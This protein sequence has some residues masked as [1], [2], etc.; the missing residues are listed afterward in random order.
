MAHSPDIP[1]YIYNVLQKCC[2][3]PTVL[4]CV[5]HVD[6]PLVW[7]KERIKK[8]RKV[9]L[10]CTEYYTYLLKRK[11]FK[12]E[13]RWPNRRLSINTQNRTII[14][15]CESLF[16]SRRVLSAK[17]SSSNS[18]ARGGVKPLNVSGIKGRNTFLGKKNERKKRT[19]ERPLQ[20]AT[21][22]AFSS[23]EAQRIEKAV[24]ERIEEAEEA[25][26]LLNREEV[27]EKE[28]G[29]N[30]LLMDSLADGDA[31]QSM[32]PGATGR[33]REEGEEDGSENSEDERGGSTDGRGGLLHADPDPLQD[34]TS[35]LE[36]LLRLAPSRY[37]ALT[38]L[39][40][41]EVADYRTL[42]NAYLR[43]EEDQLLHDL[44]VFI[45]EN[46]G[47][48]EAL[49][50][51]HYSSF[52]HAVEQCL[53]I[54]P[55]DAQVVG[56]HLS[57]AN[58]MVKSAVVNMKDAAAEMLALS[59]TCHNLEAT[60][61]LLERFVTLVEALEVAETQV[62]KCKLQGAVV[63]IRELVVLAAPLSGFVLGEYVLHR[64]AQALTQEVLTLAIQ[65]LNTWLKRLRQEA[66]VI[67]RAAMEWKGFHVP[68]RVAKRVVFAPG[69][70]WWWIGET[71]LPAETKMAPFAAADTVI[72][73]SNGA[74]IQ[75]VFEELHRGEDFRRYYCE[76]RMQQAQADFFNATCNTNGLPS[77]R[78]VEDFEQFC[79]AA[80]GFIL[81]EDVVHSATYPHVQ[82]CSEILWS[83]DQLAS[84]IAGHLSIVSSALRPDP[85]YSTYLLRIMEM[86]R[87][88]LRHALETVKSVELNPLV[89]LRVMESYTDS[90][91]STWLQ[92][93]CMQVTTDVLSDPLLALVAENNTDL[94][95]YATRFHMHLCSSMQLN[96]PS[97]FRGSHVSLPYGELVPKVGKVAVEFVRKC[98]DVMVL[99]SSSTIRHSEMNN[100]NEMILKYVSVLFRTVAEALR[101]VEKSGSPPSVIKSA[102]FLS[103]C[104]VMPVIAS[105]VEQEFLLHGP[106]DMRL[107][108]QKLG[109]P[110]V[111]KA[112]ADLFTKP[113][114]D[115]MERLLS[116]CIADVTARLALSATITYW[117]KQLDLRE[118]NEE[119]RLQEECFENCIQY[120][121]QL[122]PQLSS[123]LS[124]EITR[125]VVST[126]MVHIGQRIQNCVEMALKRAYAGSD[127][128]FN[129]MRACVGEFEM[130][131]ARGVPRWQYQL[132]LLL[133]GITAAE[134]FPLDVAGAVEA[135]RAWIDVREKQEL[136]DKQN[137]TQLMSAVE[138]AGK[139]LTKGMHAFGKTFG[140]SFKRKDEN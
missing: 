63:A 109:S 22:T 6:P 108:K 106:S 115:G 31:A 3:S 136:L 79:Y 4:F 110:V 73:L 39:V 41:G 49:C 86:L 10:L 45:K 96:V 61:L 28:E 2:D 101:Q 114:Q 17:Q 90:V 67:G 130:Q 131:C 74:G 82:S 71:F 120:I 33:E 119:Q 51:A 105:C 20:G 81:I 46:E 40:D 138:D 107:Q 25:A 94:E 64:R 92:E 113:A 77:D 68:G 60:R 14:L 80:L 76:G 57:A 59:T 124:G 112:C 16:T 12:I 69:G 54:S 104:T 7:Q 9:I 53:M 56:E 26:A 87:R 34:G 139:V 78:I 24:S 123:L 129:A 100:V 48:V 99:D 21:L 98:C 35:K 118:T 11:E 102:I 8:K 111:L 55:Q 62:V 75:Q 122:I 127:R 66:V 13:G 132:R 117:Y 103:S 140:T 88:L 116:A 1:K 70:D 95:Q 125:S 36:K 85:E 126:A 38:S 83:W 32:R 29:G 91:V 52:I 65:Q 89:L 15:S 58:A 72:D 27:G 47:R 19:L 84:S 97:Q 44:D 30:S 137:A 18:P 5:G 37:I 134:R 121:L 133:P 93:A 23:A 128:N 50:Q 135:A 43:H 42:R